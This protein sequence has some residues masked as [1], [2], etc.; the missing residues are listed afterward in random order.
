[1]AHPGTGPLRL[2]AVNPGTGALLER[3][4]HELALGREADADDSSIPPDP[5]RLEVVAYTD[6]R[7]Y[8]DP[9]SELRELQR[10]IAAGEARRKAP[11]H[12]TPALGLAVRDLEAIQTDC[13]GHHLAVVQD[14]TRSR[15]T[16]P[17]GGDGVRDRTTATFR[18]LLTPLV[19]ERARDGSPHWYVTPALRPRESG[20]PESEI[21]SAHEA[22]QA[23]VAARLG[24]AQSVPALEVSLTPADR[25]RYEAVHERADWVITLDRGIGPE[26]FEGPGPAGAAKTRY[27]LDY[28]PDFLEGL[29]KKLTVTTVHHDEVRRVLGKAMHDLDITQD[30]A[31]V[32]LV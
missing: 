5:H 10:A 26:I 20:T 1:M 29:G 19:S 14:I 24:L 15:V 4:L 27:L 9:V 22:H 23:A 31:S 3:S 12:L 32:S 16:G 28:T 6:R 8:T 25:D 7:S 30:E 17:E 13:E 2:M 21:I 18:D 11:T